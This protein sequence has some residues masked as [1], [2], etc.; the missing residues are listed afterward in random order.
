M[1]LFKTFSARGLILIVAATACT[2]LPT[3]P[4]PSGPAFAEVIR[5]STRIT[6]SFIGTNSCTEEEVLGF[7]T[8]LLQ[9]QVVETKNGSSARLSVTGHGSGVGSFGNDYRI[10]LGTGAVLNV[11]R[12]ETVRFTLRLNVTSTGPGAGKNLRGILLFK[13][14]VNAN[15][16]VTADVEHVSFSCDAIQY[17]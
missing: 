7:L 5:E 4:E 14:T 13:T 8:L 1:S 17:R 16:T 10:S 11:A 9:E 2:E 15:G 3:A 12:G 6:E